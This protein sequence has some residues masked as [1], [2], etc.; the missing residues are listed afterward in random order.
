ME[1]VIILGASDKPDRYSF[2]AYKLLSEYGHKCHLIHPTL[3]NIEGEKVYSDL[4]EIK[5]RPDTLTVYINPSLSSKLLDKIIKLNPK[6]II[7]NP[8][9]ENPELYPKLNEENIHFEEAC[10]L[11]LLRTGQY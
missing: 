10:T 9:S 5:L 1:N 7:F 3:S 11:V 8:G 6:R 2:K 4:E